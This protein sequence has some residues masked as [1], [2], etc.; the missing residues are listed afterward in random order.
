M[1]FGFGGGR[2]GWAYTDAGAG[3]GFFD[4]LVGAL[5]AG[6]EGF[7]ILPCRLLGGGLY[8]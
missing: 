1:W 4:G 8:A 5:A 7:A 6:G 2:M 3:F